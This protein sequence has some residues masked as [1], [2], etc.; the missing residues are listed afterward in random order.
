MRLL[1]KG[2]TQQGYQSLEASDKN[3]EGVAN[4][5]NDS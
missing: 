3:V 4:S 5:Y 1:F 2:F